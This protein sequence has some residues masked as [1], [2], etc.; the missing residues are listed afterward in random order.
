[1]ARSRQNVDGDTSGVNP[2]KTYRGICLSDPRTLVIVS[3][4]TGIVVGLTA[5]FSFEITYALSVILGF[6]S[7]ITFFFV[8]LS[9]RFFLYSRNGLR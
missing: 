6:A 1:V 8:I 7:V 5:Y 9:T 4:I 2:M 3:I